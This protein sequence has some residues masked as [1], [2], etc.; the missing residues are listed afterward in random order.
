[1]GSEKIERSDGAPLAVGDGAELQSVTIEGALP[2]ERYGFAIEFKLGPYPIDAP[3]SQRSAMYVFL[4]PISQKTQKALEWIGRD[5]I[6]GHV[7]LT[8]QGALDV[9]ADDRIKE[10]VCR[11]VLGPALG[12][13]KQVEES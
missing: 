1:M 8:Q 2:T 3:K 12:L 6:I 4:T 10:A 11:M 5:R 13:A 7:P 9:Q